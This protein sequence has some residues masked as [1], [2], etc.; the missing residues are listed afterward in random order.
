MPSGEVPGTTA[1]AGEAPRQG[2]SVRLFV[3]VPSCN[4][5]PFELLRR[6]VIDD[7][8]FGATALDRQIVLHAVYL[9]DCPAHRLQSRGRLTV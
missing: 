7:A 9:R 8:D 6:R 1:C 4:N 5:M 3:T 2:R